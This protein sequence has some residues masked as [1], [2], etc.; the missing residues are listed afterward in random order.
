MY[1]PAPLMLSGVLWVGYLVAQ[2]MAGTPTALAFLQESPLRPGTRL[3][4]YWEHSDGARGIVQYRFEDAGEPM[5]RI[6][7]DAQ[8]VGDRPEVYKGIDV[9]TFDVRSGLLDGASSP[10]ELGGHPAQRAGEHL[11]LYGPRGAS[12]GSPYINEWT[13]RGRERFRDTWDAWK[14]HDSESTATRY[15]D[16]ATGVYVGRRL[17]GVGYTV[18]EWLVEATGPGGGTGP[19]PGVAF[20]PGRDRCRLPR[21]VVRARPPGAGTPR[22]RGASR[23]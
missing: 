12:V 13:V 6:L 4:Y 8:I 3:T 10:W 9:G 17:V 18:D 11:A 16:T 21:P 19:G 1:G 15:F 2:R 7:A 23:D 20:H 22:I 5:V 14:V